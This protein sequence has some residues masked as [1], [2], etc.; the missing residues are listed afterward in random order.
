M[1]FF[2]YQFLFRAFQVITL[3][4]ELLLA[5]TYRTNDAKTERMMLK[6]CQP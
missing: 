6:L 2:F 1:F 4:A 3:N 5:K